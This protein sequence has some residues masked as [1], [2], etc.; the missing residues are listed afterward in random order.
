MSGETTPRMAYVVMRRLE[1]PGG[2]DLW[3]PAAVC[4]TEREAGLLTDGFGGIIKEVP[5]VEVVS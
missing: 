2:S 4:R 3:M 1:V 5:V